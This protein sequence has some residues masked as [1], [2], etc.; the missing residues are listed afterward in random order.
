MTWAYVSSVMLVREWPTISR[1]S[2]S[3]TPAIMGMVM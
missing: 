1:T 3:G 2:G